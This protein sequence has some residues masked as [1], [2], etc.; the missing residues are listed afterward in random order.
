MHT[1]IVDQEFFIEVAL[2]FTNQQFKMLKNQR[3]LNIPLFVPPIQNIK[4]INEVN[5]LIYQV[6]Q[7]PIQTTS[8]MNS[9]NMN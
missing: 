2:E 3:K 8:P 4:Q 5:D 1:D 6:Y 9:L 7:I